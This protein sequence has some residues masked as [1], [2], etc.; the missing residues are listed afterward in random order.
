MKRSVE[1]KVSSGELVIDVS[2]KSKS[3]LIARCRLG[4]QVAVSVL[5]VQGVADNYPR[6]CGYFYPLDAFGNFVPGAR[7]TLETW[8]FD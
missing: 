7:P 6:I 5:N 1:G 8:F 2:S 3:A 4:N